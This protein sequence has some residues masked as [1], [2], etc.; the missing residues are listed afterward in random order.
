MNSLISKIVL[1]GELTVSRLGFGTIHLTK[2][3]GFGPARKNAVQL[4]RRAVELGV[5]FIDTADSYGP[6]TTETIVHEALHLLA[7]VLFEARAVF[8]HRRQGSEVR[9]FRD[10]DSVC[11][12]RSREIA[13]LSGVRRGNQ[14]SSHIV[15]PGYPLE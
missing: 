5:D 2:E 11:T 3:R 4:L 15:R 9:D 10:P 6:E 8:D 13:Q 1:G 12:R 14:D 7:R